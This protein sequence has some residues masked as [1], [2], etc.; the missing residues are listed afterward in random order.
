MKWPRA[1]GIRARA[2]AVPFWGLLGAV[3]AIPLLAA[4][5]G[6]Q[7]PTVQAG[8]KLSG[9]AVLQIEA[10]LAAKAQRTPAQRK[11]NSQLLD[12]RRTPLRKPTAAGSSRFQATDPD[13][14]D[15]QVMVD[16][17]AEVTPAVL[18]R[19]RDLG[20]TVI[21]SVPRY[22][23][24]RARLPLAGVEKLAALDAIRTIRPADEARTRTQAAPLSPA[25]RTRTADFPVTRQRRHVPG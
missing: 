16:I 24:T 6:A 5:V 21:T 13:A 12:A 18:T 10:L 19:I 4:S 3:V 23:A 11:V 20:G 7:Q 14:K 22:R 15:E 2:G 25:P 9:K 8:G 1:T 17:R